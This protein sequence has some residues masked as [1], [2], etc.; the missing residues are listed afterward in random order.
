MND[1]NI[2]IDYVDN[3]LLPTIDIRS[4]RHFD[5]IVVRNVPKPWELLGGGIMRLY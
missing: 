4:I 1:I 5:P 3:N 2:L